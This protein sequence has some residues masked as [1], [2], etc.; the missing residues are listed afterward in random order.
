MQPHSWYSNLNNILKAKLQILKNKCIHFF[1]NGNS[2]TNT[3]L[4][5]LEKINFLRISNGLE[6]CIS[7]I[8]FKYFNNFAPLYINNVSTIAGQIYT[9]AT[10]T[11]LN[12][13]SRCEK[14]IEGKKVI[15]MWHLV[16]GISCQIS[17]R[18]QKTS[19]RINTKL[20]SIFFIEWTL[21]KTTF[22]ATSN[23]SWIVNAC[24]PMEIKPR[25]FFVLSLQ[26]DLVYFFAAETTCLEKSGPWVIVQ[27]PLDQS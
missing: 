27:K 2:R 17:K 7:S 6:Q 14:P 20:K 13:S 8:I 10:R 18:Q 23:W 16:S 12:W 3:G 19:T 5:G 15:N 26:S 4:T 11:S 25:S 1:L 22:I 21:K 9:S 24:L